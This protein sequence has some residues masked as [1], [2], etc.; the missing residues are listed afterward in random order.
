MDQTRSVDQIKIRWSL[1]L[2]WN[3]SKL[4]VL[5]MF[6]ILPWFYSRILFDWCSRMHLL[7][8]ITFVIIAWHLWPSTIGYFYRFE[9][10]FQLGMISKVDMVILFVCVHVWV[11]SHCAKIIFGESVSHSSF[12]VIKFDKF[13]SL[14]IHS[15][16]RLIEIETEKDKWNGGKYLSI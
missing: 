10:S 12:E 15:H 4:A 5:T 9:R 8:Q 6:Q 14:V 13:K 11:M 1:E 16:W 3:G 7:G 2:W